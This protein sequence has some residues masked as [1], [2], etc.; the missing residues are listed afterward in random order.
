MTESSFFYQSG[1]VID[2]FYFGLK[3]ISTFV[4]PNDFKI[5]AVIDPEKSLIRSSS[6]KFFQFFGIEDSIVNHAAYIH[7]KKQEES[8]NEF[9][10]YRNGF[11][12]STNKRYF[13]VQ[14]IGNSE[15]LQLSFKDIDRMKLTFTYSSA[16]FFKRMIKQTNE[17]L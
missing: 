13:T 4:M 11:K 7:D 1:D 16:A 14:C 9:L 3:G 17:I 2:N 8:N 12:N 15:V 10:F 6:M 5:C